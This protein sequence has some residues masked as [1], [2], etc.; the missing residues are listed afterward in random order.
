[1][2]LVRLLGR[3]VVT[4]GAA[5]ALPALAAAM[6]GR[7]GR[8]RADAPLNAVSHIAWS[9]A[10]PREAGPLGRNTAVGVA[11][12]A[13]ASVF[14][15]GFYEALFGRV[16]RRSTSAAFVG[17]SLVAGAAYVTDYH[18]VA[19]R[20]RPGFEAF[21]SPRA[22]VGV[23][24]ALAIGLAL[25]ARSNKLGHP[26]TARDSEGKQCRDPA[27]HPQRVQLPSTRSARP[28]VADRL[29]RARR[30]AQLDPHYREPAPGG[31]HV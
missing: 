31:E 19:R 14:W 17:A 27:R 30:D 26:E 1:M 8:G 6:G 3:V 22:L 2:S 11:L 21:L 12:H 15:A 13:G 18:R 4:G 23:Y 16:A 20:F 24:A 10:P 5:A 29:A 7:A 25:G 9:G 28:T